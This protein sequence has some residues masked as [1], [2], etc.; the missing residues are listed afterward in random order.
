MIM[1]HTQQMDMQ[2][3]ARPLMQWLRDNCHPHVRIIVEQ[4]TAEVTETLAR[5]RD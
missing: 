5:V 1:T 4:Y 3:T 2:E